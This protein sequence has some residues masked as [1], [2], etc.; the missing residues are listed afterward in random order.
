MPPTQ[1]ARDPARF[2]DRSA[3]EAW[4]ERN[5]AVSS[6]L[7]LAI[8][9]ANTGIASVTYE[10][11][12]ETALCFGWIDGQKRRGEDDGFWLQR[13]TPRTRRSPWSRINREK[14]ERLIRAGRMRDAGLAEVE[15]AKAD[16]RWERAYAGSATAELP[17]ELSAQFEREPALRDTFEALNASERYSII[18]R[19]ND[20]K[21]PET[22]ERRVAKYL[23]ALRSARNA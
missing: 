5:H 4:L 10:Q 22:R 19:I 23:D 14:A 18:W 1:D 16:G 12:V 9:K 20:A 15:R 8:A 2:A 17:P 21:R 6:E 13:F 3:F 7:W 11:A